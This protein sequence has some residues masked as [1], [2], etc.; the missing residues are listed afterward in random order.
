MAE[1][2]ETL[3]WVIALHII[4]RTPASELPAAARNRL[5]QAL[6]EE[7]WGEAVEIWLD[8]RPDGIDVYPSHVLYV[9]RD[10]ALAAQELQFSPLF[11]G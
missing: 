10:V 3:N 11:D 4:A 5:R 6:R 9:E 2:I 1:D 7:Q 8:V